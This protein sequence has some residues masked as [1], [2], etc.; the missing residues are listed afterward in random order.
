M[1][2]QSQAAAGCF[3]VALKYFGGHLGRWSGSEKTNAQNFGGRGRMAPLHPLIGQVKGLLS[4]PEGF[5]LVSSD[6]AQIEA[7]ILAWLAGQKDLLDGFTRGEDIYSAFARGLLYP[8]HP[9]ARAHCKI[10]KCPLSA[11]FVQVHLSQGH[12]LARAHCNISKCPL[13][14]A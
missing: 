1:I 3:P 11:A 6:Y 8:G 9:L 10:S 7:R 5:V 13:I 12:P 4:A 2:G 14:A